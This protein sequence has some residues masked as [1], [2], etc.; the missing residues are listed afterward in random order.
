VLESFLK[1]NEALRPIKSL[2]KYLAKKLT[3]SLQK[4]NQAP[5]NY[6][7]PCRNSNKHTYNLVPCKNKPKH[8]DYLIPCKK[9]P[10]HTDCLIP[11]KTEPTLEDV[12]LEITTAL[13]V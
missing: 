6:L 3:D 10:K 8:T 7:T 12:V 9:E 11:C 2:E 4:Q 5:F 1:P 13:F